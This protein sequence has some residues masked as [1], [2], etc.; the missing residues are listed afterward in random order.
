[1]VEES[2]KNAP[3]KHYRTDGRKQQRRAGGRKEK[4]GVSS[5]VEGESNRYLQATYHINPYLEE[6]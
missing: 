6:K 4:R 2:A 1:M 3:S 5:G